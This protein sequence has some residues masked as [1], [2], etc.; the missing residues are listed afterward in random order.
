MNELGVSVAMV[1]WPGDVR[2]IAPTVGTMSIAA[3]GL[4]YLACYLGA[5]RI[6][7]ALGAP[8]AT[9]ILRLLCLH[10]L[11]DGVT[12]VPVG[13]LTRE[14]RQERRM[15]AD[16]T[17]FAASTGVTLVLA[18]LGFG[19]W[20]LAWGR[21][22]GSGLSAVLFLRLA[23]Q[24]L[25]LGFDRRQARELLAFGLPLA[26]SSLL[27]FAMLNLD[28]IV[29]GRLLGPVQ[30][31]LYLLAFNLSSWPVN[32]FSLAVRRVS[33]AGF[34]RLVDDPAAMR[35][36]F[37]RAVALILA[38]TAPV[39]ALLGAFAL[40]LIRFVYGPRWADAAA[41]LSF[42]AVLAALRVMLELAYDFLVAL[43]RSRTVLWLQAGWVAT[44][45]PALALGAVAGDIRG[46]G[47]GHVLVGLV[48]VAPAFLVV[49]RRV[50]VS[51]S[52]LA[53]G[54]ARPLLGAALVSATAALVLRTVSGDFWQLAV[55]GTLAL[56]LYVL[57]T[58]P[59]RHLLRGGPTPEA[60][61]DSAVS[62]A[63]P[64]A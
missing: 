8:G 60:A 4:F 12:A 42:L 45:A 64:A 7:V 13:L 33:L 30:L 41:A 62:W 19:A 34:S 18:V 38:A 28:Y 5:P 56:S 6:A 11:V 36:G 40:P 63:A 23:P 15:V 58:L 26:G 3:S 10:V 49:L 37:V 54:C 50:G 20:S 14:F 48:V 29:V 2:R 59:M 39:C 24:R 61:A 21:L 47:A 25:R 35:S 17:G 57:V 16:L 22:A 53:R 27:V 31:G 9:G 43:G 32:M 52:D 55:G 1:R 51:L 46:V 44:L